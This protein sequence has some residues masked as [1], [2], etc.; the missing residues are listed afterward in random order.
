[1]SWEQQQTEELEMATEEVC[2]N[3]EQWKKK[4]KGKERTLKKKKGACTSEK[5]SATLRG[6][7]LPFS[8]CR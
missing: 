5:V 2:K 8:Q 1:M 7:A 3:W 6:A 4:M